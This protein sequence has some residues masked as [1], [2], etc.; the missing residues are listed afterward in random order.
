MRNK[1][2]KRFCQFAGTERR[3]KNGKRGRRRKKKT[4]A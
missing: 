3:K 1:V 2:K 4:F